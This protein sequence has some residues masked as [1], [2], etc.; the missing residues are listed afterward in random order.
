MIDLNIIVKHL[1]I[2]TNR[3]RRNSR[4]G[5]STLKNKE[6]LI[7]KEIK[8]RSESRRGKPIGKSM[9]NGKIKVRCKNKFN[10]YQKVPQIIK[11]KKSQKSKPKPPN[12]TNIKNRDTLIG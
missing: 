2:A 5:K 9:I 10:I 7:Q 6:N 11:K 4:R 3:N 1:V 8:I 12:L